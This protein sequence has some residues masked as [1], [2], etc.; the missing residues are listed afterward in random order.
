MFGCLKEVVRDIFL[1]AGD[2][3]FKWGKPL[4]GESF[5]EELQLGLVY[6]EPVDLLVLHGKAPNE[7]VRREESFPGVA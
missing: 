7:C 6:L 3:A 4:V 1:N 5:K 2:V